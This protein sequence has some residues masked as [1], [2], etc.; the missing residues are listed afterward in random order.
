MNPSYCIRST[1]NSQELF[2]ATKILLRA[3]HVKFGT[4][5]YE[6]RTTFFYLMLKTNS[7]EYHDGIH[8]C[9]L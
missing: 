8:C 2:R 5:G 1:G 6:V 7:A 9:Y 3:T 4:T